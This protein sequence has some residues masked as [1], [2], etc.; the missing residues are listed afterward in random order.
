MELNSEAI[1]LKKMFD[2]VKSNNVEKPKKNEKIED[3]KVSTEEY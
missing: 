3:N 1:K 2:K